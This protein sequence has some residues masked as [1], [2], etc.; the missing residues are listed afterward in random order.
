METIKVVEILAQA[1]F[2]K[3]IDDCIKEAIILALERG[4]NVKL[5]HNGN[6]DINPQQLIESIKESHYED[7]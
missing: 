2:G 4:S 7:N 6:Y 5:M 1:S 3:N